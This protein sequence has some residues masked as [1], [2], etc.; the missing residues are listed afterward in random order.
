M[1]VAVFNW[2]SGKDSALALHY[3]LRDN[4]Y[5][6]K[7]LATNINNDVKRVSMHGLREELLENQAACI[8]LPLRKIYFKGEVTMATYETLMRKEAMDLI[9][10]GVRYTIFGDI[11]LE[12]LKTYRATL[13]KGLDFSLIYPLW[14]QDTRKLLLEFID[15]GFKAI[16]VCVNANKLDPSFLGRIID[17]DFINDLPKGVDPCGE[18]GEFHTF[19]YDGPIFNYPVEFVLGKTII[20]T[21]DCPNDTSSKWDNTFWYLDV[22][23]K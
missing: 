2:S 18:N 19:V 11:F 8:G 6:V 21:Y 16:L 3:I 22:L 9:D 12:D 4:K 14:K 15:L 5:K 20:K 13:H 7:Y 10:E 1:P 23:P 17:R